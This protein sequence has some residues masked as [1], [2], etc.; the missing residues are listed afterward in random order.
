M[1]S[2]SVMGEQYSKESGGRMG[3]KCVNRKNGYVHF[4][5]SVFAMLEVYKC[6][7]VIKHV[8]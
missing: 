6:L 1:V 5:H 7:C 2:K 3:L 4:C 8:G